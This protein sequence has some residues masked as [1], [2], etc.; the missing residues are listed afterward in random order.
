MKTLKTAKCKKLILISIT[1]FTALFTTA[2][3][4]QNIKGVILDKDSKAT[5]PFASVFVLNSK[6]LIGTTSD[7]DGKFILKNVPVGR[8]TIVVQYIGYEQYVN[9]SIELT[10]GKEIDLTI[11][12]K[13]SFTKLEEV[14]IVAKSREAI[15][16]ISSQEFSIEETKRFAASFNDP[17]RMAQSYA[18][19]SSNDDENNE[20]VIRGNSPK[21][22]LWRL[23]GIEIP[24]P[25]HFSNG[26]GG[27]GGGVSMISNAVLSNSS[28]LTGAFSSEYGNAS[29]GVFDLKFRKGNSDK[30]EYS[31]QIGILGLQASAE[32]PIGKHFSYLV[33]YRYS[34]LTLL[35]NAGIKFGGENSIAPIFQDVNFKLSLNTKK[36]GIFKL[37][38]LGGFSSAGDFAIKDTSK[39]ENSYDNFQEKENHH[40]GV[41]ILSNFY[42]LKNNKTSF[43]SVVSSSDEKNEVK[44]DSL[45]YNYAESNVDYSN[46]KNSS[47]RVSETINHKFNIKNTVSGGV[48]L[49]L[50]NYNS[51]SKS[52]NNLGEMENKIKENGSTNLLQGF[53]KGKHRFSEKL[54][55]NAGLHFIYLGLNNNFSVE[56]RFSLNY[57]LNKTQSI[58]YGFGKHSKMES[59]S[60][61]LAKTDNN[62]QENKDLKFQK[63]IHNVLGY[64]WSF[65]R[66]FNLKVETYH[67]YLY[68]IPV[69]KD[70][71]FY[72]L[73]NESSGLATK[74]LTN[75]GTGYNYGMELTV[76]K[77][78]SNN[79]YFMVTASV[80]DSKYKALDNK[81]RNTKFNSSYIF[82]ML[83]GKEFKIGKRNT[84]GLNG[85]V[86]WRGG[87]KTIPLDL[88]KSIAQHKSIYITE[89]AY[90]T[91]AP[92]YF[93][94]DLSVNFK[95]NNPKYSW[96]LA[97]AFQ[98]VTNHLNLYNEYF[99]PISN[100]IERTNYQGLVPNLNFKMDF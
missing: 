49:S 60:I 64:Q 44:L 45:D 41:I 21:G 27:S 63:S 25:N 50:L 5:I 80:F 33:N 76:E 67:Q 10:S 69:A 72:S 90:K 38:G 24:N 35:H 97:L 55:L 12:L 77:S 81:W 74:N 39:W 17:A 13:E 75:K 11:E 78:F 70:S 58:S 68:N 46:F 94:A 52:L 85:R 30:R 19:V 15:T 6:P 1:L 92:N 88:D 59:T 3:I 2:Q 98:N 9:S 22:M 56:P 62:L 87:Y 84:I 54:S 7:I 4:T 73:L 79:Y 42:L 31:I 57:K 95:R 26:E 71:S 36:A 47:L 16:R 37:S 96:T 99:S 18:G 66:N 34:T 40:T 65:A 51:Y 82:N 29:S 28:F 100:K 14:T 53:A 83:G 43:R 48:I 93:R 89:K 8:K 61:Y 86:I 32:G 20:I 23:D 91:K